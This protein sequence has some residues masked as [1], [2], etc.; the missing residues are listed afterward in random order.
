MQ[1]IEIKPQPKQEL[2]LS[3]PADILIFGGAAGGGK[4]WTLMLEITRHRK[5]SGFRSVTFRRTSPQI[6]NPGGL[7]DES[8]NLFPFLNAVPKE[9]DHEWHFP[10]KAVAKFAHLQ[11]E[12]DIKSWQGA[13]IAL[14]E[15]DELTHFTEKQ[16]FYLL[17]RNRSTCGVKPYV[18]CSTNPDPDSWVAG[19]IAWWI[20]QETGYAIEERAGVIRWFWRVNGEIHW[21]NTKE[22][23]IEDFPESLDDETG[24]FLGKSCTFIPSKLEDNQI[25]MKK[26]PGY[27]ANLMAQ[28][29]VE[30]ERL[31]G[32]NWKIKN[33]AGKVFNRAWF[34]IKTREQLP[35]LDIICSFWDLAATEKQLKGDD[36]DY[37]AR[38]MIGYSIKEQIFVILDAFQTQASPADVEKLMAQFRTTDQ[39]TARQFGARFLYRWEIEP[40]S[41]GK[42]ESYRLTTKFAGTDAT[43][44]RDQRGKIERAKALSRQAEAGNVWLLSGAW[45][46]EFLAHMHSQPDAAHD[47]L[48]DGASGAFNEI[49]AETDLAFSFS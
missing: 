28:S 21:R 8:Q 33:E 19:F 10:S 5:N 22:E 16:F 48:M 31:H 36:P 42:R 9:T 44:K 17:S 45:N 2:A 29:L 25:L 49:S 11:H 1:K 30:R 12:K 23:I 46:N 24:D 14:L 32:G 13:A 37:S 27:K 43:G 41:A 15:F 4:S 18:R 35:K 7:W 40:G 38:V 3:S 6:T 39:A 34:Q 47:D 26:D 20:D